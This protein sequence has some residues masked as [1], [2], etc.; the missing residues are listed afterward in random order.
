MPEMTPLEAKLTSEVE[1]L[2]EE[3]KLLREK[4]DLLVRRVFGNG[5]EKVDTDQLLLAMEGLEAKK[6]EASS[7]AA[8]ALE[9][10]ESTKSKPTS[11]RGKRKGGITDEMLDSLPAVE[12]VIDPEE[13]KAEPEAW[14]QVDEQVTKQLDYQPA[15]Y[16]CRRIIRRRY[17]K[18]D[19]PHRPP[20][21]AE[22]PTMLE[23]SKAG[24][25]LLASILTA[26][27]C[28][29][30]PLYRQQQIAKLRHSIDLSRQDMSRWV[31]LAA[32]WLRPLYQIIL[33]GVWSEGYAQVDETVIK[34]LEPGTGRA[35]QGYFWTIKRPEGDAVFHWATTRAAT[36][37]E[38]IIPVDFDGTIQCDGYSAYRTFAKRHG[39]PVTLAACWAHARREF[40]EASQ[41]GA[42]KADALLIVR[43]IAHLYAIEA[44]LRESQA[45]AKL[46]LLARQVE[47]AP[48]LERIRAVL[49]R[50][51]KH[52]RHLPKSQMGKAI[53]YTLTLWDQLKVF[54]DDGRLEIDNNQVE[55]AIRPT[56]VGKKN[57]LFI[58][59]A[60]A[61]E[62]GAIIFTVIE[63]CRR[64]GLDPFEYLRDVFTRMPT[65]AAKDYPSLLPQA[66]AKIQIA[67]PS[68]LHT[69]LR[70]TVTLV[71]PNLDSI[72]A[73]PVRETDSTQLT[74]WRPSNSS[75][76]DACS[77]LA[78]A[79]R[80]LAPILLE[81]ILTLLTET[82][83]R[84]A[85]ARATAPTDDI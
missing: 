54:A 36:V 10:E 78:N 76:G 60:Q 39:Q 63:A 72:S 50:W 25:G 30:L 42:H 22:L 11:T 20:I 12:V 49:E 73:L 34:Y 51:T 74:G 53:H 2:R 40:I 64:R 31:G 38:K 28:D 82:E 23:R 37:L 56:A 41:T 43:L 57:W 4:I 61:G 32:E 84:I 79:S 81:P 83:S 48:V 58:G 13:V 47:S 66:H 24:P 77:T 7:D 19:E 16:V 18:H 85:S 29:H 27:Y 35:Q 62:R 70:V 46:R 65:M 55:N 69:A 68:Q 71:Y 1:A 9:A 33:G 45:S 3:N 59:E 26:K 21:I 5:S 75:S 8:V 52:R 17:V 80:P 44:R 14:R 15:K 67:H 6:P